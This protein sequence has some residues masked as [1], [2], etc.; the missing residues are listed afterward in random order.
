MLMEDVFLG[1]GG[2]GGGDAGFGESQFHGSGP[3][4]DGSGL[5]IGN[6]TGLK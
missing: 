3:C 1:L 4:R 2:S 6:R 5:K